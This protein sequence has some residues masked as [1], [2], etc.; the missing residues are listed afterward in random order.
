MDHLDRYWIGLSEYGA[1]GGEYTWS[2]GT[3]VDYVYWNPGNNF[4]K[5]SKVQSRLNLELL[6]KS[7]FS[8]TD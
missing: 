5:I 1:I 7:I 3:V 8:L 4:I 2:D 6:V